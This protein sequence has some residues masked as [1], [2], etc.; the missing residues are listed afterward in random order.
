MRS[1]AARDRPAPRRKRGGLTGACAP[2]IEPNRRAG[3]PLASRAGP[4]ARGGWAGARRGGA[5][6]VA[7]AAA[8]ASAPRVRLRAQQVRA[9]LAVE[10]RGEFVRPPPAAAAHGPRALVGAGGGQAGLWGGNELARATGVAGGLGRRRARARAAREPLAPI[11]AG[12]PRGWAAGVP[13]AVHARVGAGAANR[14]PARAPPR[15][16][17]ALPAQGRL[18]RA[19][20]FIARLHSPRPRLTDLRPCPTTPP[21]ALYAPPPRRDAPSSPSPRSRAPSAGRQPLAGVAAACRAPWS[22]APRR[23]A[24]SAPR[25]TRGSCCW[26]ATSACRASSWR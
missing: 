23:A 7:H 14:A 25:T 8:S 20:G 9:G 12:R 3:R 1:P 17:I 13:P 26:P 24:A 21:R 18:Q 19:P 10:R 5:G 6:A 15:A 22:A 11:Q 16:A 2:W 4:G